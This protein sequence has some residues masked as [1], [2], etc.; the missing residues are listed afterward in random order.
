MRDSSGL[1]MLCPKCFTFN[2]GPV[3]THVVVCWFRD[4]G[5]PD[6]ID[7]SPGRWTPSGAG[8]DDLT[9]VPGNPARAVSVLLTGGCGWHGYVRGGA[10][11]SD[12]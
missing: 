11:D 7:P 4:R 6:D 1:Y 5:V 2:A 10:V 12:A 3:G 8:L 9:F